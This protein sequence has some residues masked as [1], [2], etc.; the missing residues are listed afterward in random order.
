MKKFLALIGICTLLFSCGKNVSKD[1]T[2][3]QEKSGKY[4]LLEMDG[5]DI[6]GENF[7]F[8]LDAANQRLS[9]KT[10]CNNFV[11]SYE[12][13]E[14][15]SLKF[16]PPL[17]TKMYCEGQMEYEETFGEI[18]PKIVKVEISAEEL[19]FLSKANKTLLKLQKQ[20]ASE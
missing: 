12:V 3:L 5:N 8:E 2:D 10:G 9:G 6:S 4:S 15:G 17:G 20:Q 11:A 1:A 14:D 7:T 19:V 13:E 18:V 16:N